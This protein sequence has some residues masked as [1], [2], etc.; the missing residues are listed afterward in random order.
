[1]S[2]GNRFG[3][4]IEFREGAPIQLLQYVE[5]NSKDGFGKIVLNPVAL[6]ILQTIREPLAIIS[7]VGSYRRG[8]SWFANVLHGRHDGF[9][10]GAKV[11]GCTRGIYMWSPPFTLESEQPDGKIIQK[12]VIVL[13]SEGIDDPKQDQH[14]ATKLFILC[15]ALSSTFIYNINGIVGRDDI[16]KLYLM[17]D[18][19]NFIQEPEEGDFLPRLVILLR[20]FTLESPESFKDYFL[21]KLNNVNPE[22]AKGIKKF[23]YDFDVYGLPHPGCKRKMLQHMEDADT[24]ELDEEFVD[25]VENAVKSIYSQ[26]PL[27]YI[28]SSTMKGSAFVKFLNDIVERMNKSETSS[29]LSIPSEYESI[30]QFV[31]QEAIKEAV[32]VY[33]EQMDHLLNEEVKLPILWDEFTEIHNNCISEA[34]K[35]FFEKV[36]GSPTQMESFIE[37]LSEK[38][39]KIKEE[40]TKRN[41]DELTA[42]NENIAK[43]YWERYSN[44]EFQEALEAFEL[45]YE[46][47]MMK[48]PEAA[49]VIA[50]YM[51][52]QYPT[53]IEYMTQLG[54]MNAELAKAM[55]AKEEAETLRLEALARE[56]EFRREIEAQKHEREESERNFK[57]KMEELQANIDQ[58]TRSHEEMKE[59]LIKER[60]IA[61]EK[62]NQKLEQL[63]NE[64]LEQ[65]KLNE[66]DKRKLLEQ[67]Q[68]KFE[69]IQRE[70]EEA[71][72]KRT[73]EL[74]EQLRQD[75]EKAIEKQNEFFQK[76]LAEQIAA[77]ERHH[78]QM[79]EQMRRD[80]ESLRS[81][82]S[83]SGRDSPLCVIS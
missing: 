29:L 50:S 4:K 2:A 73:E 49:K 67:Q 51:Q 20:D 40:F 34:N 44:D 83:N 59:R 28:G 42:H 52:N 14:W 7:V 55:K 82:I 23:F 35:Y 69:Q 26:I 78:S 10:L 16:G 53:A 68:A 65:Q 64:M 74:K 72:R 6:N 54:R 70:A 5:D 19:S 71:N 48:S 9:D 37:E 61:A 13:D 3:R 80:N 11:E 60:D 25:E 58:Q 76:Q 30:I 41:S 12:R 32:G 57:T 62:Y 47:S 24:D 18:L 79:L 33:Q 77:S 45:A 66:E 27:K 8:K 56:E 1:M 17:T 81:A 63:H 43:D 38:M 39:S 22:A 36:I 21:E 15:L 31:A 46:K 75:K